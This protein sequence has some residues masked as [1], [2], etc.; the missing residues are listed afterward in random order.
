MKQQ[1]IDKL[2]SLMTNEKSE[3][4]M[5]VSALNGKGELR[6]G[7]STFAYIVFRRYKNTIRYKIENIITIYKY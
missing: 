1:H 5:Q 6:I 7:G 4:R 2:A 3:F